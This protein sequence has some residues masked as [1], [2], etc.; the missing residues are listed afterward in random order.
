MLPSSGMG[1]HIFQVTGSHLA[2][3]LLGFQATLSAEVWGPISS[4]VAATGEYLFPKSMGA[5][6]EKIAGQVPRL[7]DLIDGLSSA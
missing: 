6:L 3:P 7:Q 2:S 5:V 1:T 4:Q